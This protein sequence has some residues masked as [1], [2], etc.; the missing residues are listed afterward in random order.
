[1]VGIGS[2]SCVG[3]VVFKM[4]FKMENFLVLKGSIV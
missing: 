1:M 3:D 4:A 2:K